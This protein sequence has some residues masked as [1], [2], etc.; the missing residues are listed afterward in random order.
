MDTVELCMMIYVNSSDI[1]LAHITLAYRK[2]KR[3]NVCKANEKVYF[4]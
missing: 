1:G 3:L 4:S 2:K